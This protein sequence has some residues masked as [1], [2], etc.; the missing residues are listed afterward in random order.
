MFAE[1][2]FLF[3][4]DCTIHFILFSIFL[5]WTI[6]KG[7]IELAAVLLLLRDFWSFG[8]KTCRTPSPQ[9]GV[10]PTPPESEGEISAARAPG[11]SLNMWL[12]AVYWGFTGRF[13]HL[14]VLS[15][16]IQNPHKTAGTRLLTAEFFCVNDSGD[17]VWWYVSKKKCT[18]LFPLGS[19]S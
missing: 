8:H 18:H 3:F 17:V 16:K 15:L 6:F 12:K 10:E 5:M 2:R 7:Y 1:K 4:S 19:L 11:K 13:F 9:P 14:W